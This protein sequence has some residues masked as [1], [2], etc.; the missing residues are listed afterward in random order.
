MH[1]SSEEYARRVQQAGPP[2]PIVRDCL[3]AFCV[4]GGIC[5]LGEW[6]RQRYLAAGADPDTAGTLTSCTL[7]LLSGL[8]TTLGWYQKLAARAGAGSLVPITGFANSVVSAAIE[9][10]SEG[11]VTGTGA[12]MFTIAGPVIVYGTAA[13]AVYGLILWLAGLI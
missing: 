2:S 7:I 8:C 5:L 6:F 12:K 13:S 1:L 3:W 4:G 11:R 10:Q 9:F